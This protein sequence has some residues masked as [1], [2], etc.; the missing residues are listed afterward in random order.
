M[1][2]HM[3]NKFIDLPNKKK[4]VLS[5]FLS[6]CLSAPAPSPAPACLSACVRVRS[7]AYMCAY[8]RLVGVCLF[9][10][11]TGRAHRI[12]NQNNL[13][14]ESVATCAEQPS[15]ALKKDASKPLVPI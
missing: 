7:N 13:I 3:E 1:P 10:S 5:A 14:W 4:S 11:G 8:T 6:F 15:P 9:V 2:C 12:R